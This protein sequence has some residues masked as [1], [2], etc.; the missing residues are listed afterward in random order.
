[1]KKSWCYFHKNSVLG[2]VAFKLKKNNEKVILNYT[3]KGELLF[4]NLVGK[5]TKEM[6]ITDKSA[7][8]FVKVS[9][10]NNDGFQELILGGID[11][12]LR[13]Y[14]IKND[15]NLEQIWIH[16]FDSSISGIL[17]NDINYDGNLEIIAFSLDRSLRVLDIKGKLVWAQM[18]EKGIGDAFVWDDKENKKKQIFAV[19]NDGTVRVFDGKTGELLWFKLFSNKIRCL[20]IINSIYNLLLICGGDDKV[21]HLIDINNHEEIKKIP[22]PNYIW[23]CKSYPKSSLNNALISTYS[24]D[25]FDSSIPLAQ[26]KFSSQILCLN[27]NL[28]IKWDLKDVNTEYIHLFRRNNVKLV[29]IGTTKGEII[30]INEKNGKIISLINEKSCINM[31]KYLSDNDLL[32]SCND[33]GQINAYHLINL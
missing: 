17:I 21:L 31:V 30:L 20:S 23:K 15:L 14:K 32:I 13:F 19:G 29:G 5:L 16:K 28:R 18:F 27:K 1:M 9:D 25:Y 11:G 4:L 24:F 3:N 10:I 26:V 2:F 22:F 12:V 8:L 7:I 6:S 33:N